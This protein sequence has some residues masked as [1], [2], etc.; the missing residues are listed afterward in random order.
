M[1]YRTEI[2]RALDEMIFDEAGNKFQGLAVV[3]AQQKWPRL[4]ACE[5]KWD[6][7]L[8]AHANGA[9][10]PDKKGL[11][12]ACSTTATIKKI[13]RD[14]A[15]TKEDYPDVGVLIF[16]TPKRVSQ[17]TKRRW[18]KQIADEFGLT[19]QVFRAKSSSSGYSIPHSPTSAEISRL[20]AV[21]GGMVRLSRLEISNFRNFHEL[22]VSLGT[23]PGR[24]GRERGRQVELGLCVAPTT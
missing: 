5:R 20:A 9:F 22:D 11:G 16:A 15:G 1:A 14:A 6:G 23:R 4:I 19:L 2:E 24:R 13:K 12:L 17:H 18:A 10:E 7:G 8:D 3:G 21:K